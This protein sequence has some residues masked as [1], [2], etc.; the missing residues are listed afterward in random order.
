MLTLQAA[1]DEM[2]AGQGLEMIRE[3]GIDRRAADGARIGAAWAATF[4]LTTTP[5][6]AAICEISR[7][8]TGADRAVTP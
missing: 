8:T 1:H 7:A 5:K 6:R 2:P 4:S 3:G